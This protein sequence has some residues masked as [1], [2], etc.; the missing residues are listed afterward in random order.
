MAVVET[1]KLCLTLLLDCDLAGEFLALLL[2]AEFALDS[3][4]FVELACV[5]FGLGG[6][7]VLLL[8]TDLFSLAPPLT[9]MFSSSALLLPAC[10]H[11]VTAVSSSGDLVRENN[12]RASS[13]PWIPIDSKNI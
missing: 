7:V 1:N 3:F 5:T 11:V 9:L 10:A 2:A 8:A 12:L 13:T 6:P 4:C